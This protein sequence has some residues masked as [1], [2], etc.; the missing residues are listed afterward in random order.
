V[1]LT[2]PAYS[3][4]EIVLGIMPAMKEFRYEYREQFQ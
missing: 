1:P 2:I 3:R 4:R